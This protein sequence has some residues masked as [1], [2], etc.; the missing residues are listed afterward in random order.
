MHRTLLMFAGAFTAPGLLLVDSAV[1]GTA[2]LILAAVATLL[3]RRDSA[4]TRHLLWLLAI[5]ALLVLPLLSAALPEWRVLPEWA[6]IGRQA[7]ATIPSTTEAPAPGKM[8]LA[9][10]T[11]PAEAEP[12][13][14]NTIPPAV[15]GLGMALVVSPSCSQTCSPVARS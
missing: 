1:K 13:S 9:S 6:G 10:N 15:T 2:L 12:T 7:P 5:V 4:A 3:F 8:D 11:D 14:A